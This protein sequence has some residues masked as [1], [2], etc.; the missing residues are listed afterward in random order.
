MSDEWTLEDL[1][2][3][4]EILDSDHWDTTERDRTVLDLAL[5]AVVRRLNTTSPKPAPGGNYEDW[6][7]G[8]LASLAR[9]AVAQRDEALKKADASRLE[10]ERSRIPGVGYMKFCEHV[11]QR[12][13]KEFANHLIEVS[14]IDGVGRVYDRLSDEWADFKWGDYI[15]RGER[16]NFFPFRPY[17]EDPEPYAYG[18]PLANDEGETGCDDESEL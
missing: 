14:E 7:H 8:K 13:M 10:L 15:V 5:L 12:A 16:G 11:S 4:D 9:S 17:R 18:Y 3:E 1:P 2:G 6:E